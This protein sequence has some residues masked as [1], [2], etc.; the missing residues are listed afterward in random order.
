MFNPELFKEDIELLREIWKSNRV[1]FDVSV[2]EM[3]L[4]SG[5]DMATIL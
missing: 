1:E 5:Q 3:M 4:M 2:V